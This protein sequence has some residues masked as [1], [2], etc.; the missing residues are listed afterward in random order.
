M[1]GRDLLICAADRP[2]VAIDDWLNAAAVAEKVAWI[3]GANDGLTVLLFLH[4]PGQ[5]ACFECEQ[6]ASYARYDWYGEMLRYARD[7]IGDRTINPCTAPVAGT[8]G[9][10]AAL[11]AVKYLTG[12]STPVIWGRKMGFDLRAMESWYADGEKQ[13][14]C[15]VCGHLDRLSVAASW[16]K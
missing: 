2:R 8:I 4:V 16:R 9:N 6:M 14:N 5:T 3:R 10:I 11:E 1:S 7:V 15:P 13:Y 12:A